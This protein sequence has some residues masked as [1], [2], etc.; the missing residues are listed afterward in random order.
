[1]KQKAYVGRGS[2]SFCG[3]IL[4]TLGAKK[5]FLVT[6]KKSYSVSG[7]KDKL[8]NLPENLEITIFKDFENVAKLNDVMSGIELFNKTGYDAVIAV[9]G[10]SVINIAKMVNFF[11]TNKLDPEEYLKNRKRENFSKKPLIAIPTTAGSGSEATHFAVVYDGKKKYSV[12][13]ESILPEYALVDADLTMSM[14]PR[15]AAVTGMDALAQAIESYWGVNSTDL[16]REYARE[17]ISLIIENIVRAVEDPSPAS[18]EALARAAHLSGKAINITKTSAPHAVSYPLTAHFNIPHG[19]AVALTLPGFFVYNFGV[20]GRDLTDPRGVDFVK[21]R[22]VE[23]VGL[24]GSNSVEAARD[25]L[26]RIIRKVGLETRLSRITREP[27]QNVEDVIIEG[28]DTD[29]MNNNPR[30]VTIS[31]VREILKNIF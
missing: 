26:G 31:A 13:D 23:L 11:G 14:P 30:R 9:G 22:I 27:Y 24:L 5:I 16:S 8:S 29:R 28:I 20:E 1:M 19:H 21:A 17:A 7:A 2:I 6:G 10:G 12:S 3:P 25:N 4:K 15:V 18:E